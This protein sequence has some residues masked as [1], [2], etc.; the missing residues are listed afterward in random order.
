MGDGYFYEINTDEDGTI[1][2][3]IKYLYV[4]IL[5]LIKNSILY[6]FYF[7]IFNVFYYTHLLKLIKEGEIERIINLLTETKDLEEFMKITEDIL[8][9]L[10]K[11]LIFYE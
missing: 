8:K 10:I 11:G 6:T 1:F 4:F 3:W 9:V 5:L 7:V 2:V